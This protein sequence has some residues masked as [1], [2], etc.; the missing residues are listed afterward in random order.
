M[1]SS[2]L[3]EEYLVSLGASSSGEIAC[4]FEFLTS[5]LHLPERQALEILAKRINVRS[6]KAVKFHLQKKNE[7]DTPRKA[8]RPPKIPD[9]KFQEMCQWISQEYQVARY[10]TMDDI[11]NKFLSDDSFE[12]VDVNTLQHNLREAGFRTVLAVPQEVGRITL[13]SK[14]IEDHFRALSLAV[15]GVS[16]RLIIN[17]DESGFQPWVDSKDVRVWVASNHQGD[18]VQ[19]PVDRQVK[20][21]TLLAGITLSGATIRPL[22]ILPRKSFELELAALGYTDSAIFTDSKKGY[23]SKDRFILWLQN[24]V[25]PYLEE[26]RKDIGCS[27][28]KAVLILDGCS[29]HADLERIC[30]SMNLSV[31]TIPP[32]SLL[33]PLDLVTFGLL[34]KRYARVR[35]DS[36]M[37]TKM[38]Q[39]IHRILFAFQQ[40]STSS[41]NVAAFRKAGIV[42]SP[43]CS[44][45]KIIL[46]AV[47]DRQC[48]AKAMCYLASRECRQAD[49]QTGCI[50]DGISTQLLGNSGA[51]ISSD[52]SG[53]PPVV[54]SGI[55]VRDGDLMPEF[56]EIAEVGF[57]DSEVA[58]AESLATQVV[59]TLIFPSDSRRNTTAAMF[60]EPPTKKMMRKRVKPSAILHRSV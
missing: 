3:L 10:M 33:Q 48:A 20:R 60:D 27:D 15:S 17:A 2:Q 5:E 21:V 36:S 11:I 26:V 19:V 46:R 49:V 30:E 8:G 31:F 32:H 54:R 59:P 43:S 37:L 55:Q 28:S 7:T 9:E 23:V 53:D 56:D 12:D 45:N 24:A 6:T 38:T 34:K 58:H 50:P 1:D 25:K 16:A 44:D 39:N 41:N 18:S 22:V 42:L 14:L 40:S 35:L 57:N 47:V 51:N 29:S 4:G 13:T 52:A